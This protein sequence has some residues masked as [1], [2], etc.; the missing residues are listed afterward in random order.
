M[1][2]LW[3]CCLKF[4]P[5]EVLGKPLGSTS[6]PVTPGRFKSF[7]T[8]DIDGGK[9]A[10]NDCGLSCPGIA[11]EHAVSVGLPPDVLQ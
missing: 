3:E 11:D 10:S 5:A 4:N 9:D 8:T 6:G 1:L 2:E 7:P